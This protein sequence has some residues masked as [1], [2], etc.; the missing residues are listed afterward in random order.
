MICEADVNVS[1]PDSG[2]N[3][4][5]NLQNRSDFEKVLELQATGY[6]VYAKDAETRTGE[7][8]R[9]AV[10]ITSETWDT[11]KR[12]DTG[13]ANGC[14]SYEWTFTVP[15]PDGLVKEDR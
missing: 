9:H 5:F 4:S 13:T 12:I 3:K 14:E 7:I 11:L 10:L 8:V 6:R 1:K 15:Y 2:G